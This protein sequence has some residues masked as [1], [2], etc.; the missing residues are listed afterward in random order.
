LAL[1]SERDAFCDAY[2]LIDEEL[3]TF[4]TLL[5]FVFPKRLRRYQWD[6]FYGFRSDNVHAPMEYAAMRLAA[7]L[8]GIETP[9]CIDGMTAM[10]LGVKEYA[11]ALMPISEFISRYNENN[12]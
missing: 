3:A 4:G 10:E 8:T 2:N 5:P 11:S 12:A 9:E 6:W 1:Q 7:D